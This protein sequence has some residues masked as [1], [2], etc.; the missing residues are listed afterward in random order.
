MSGGKPIRDIWRFLDKVVPAEW[1]KVTAA[2]EAALRRDAGISTPPE[3]WPQR[4]A[5]FRAKSIW[6]PA[7]GPPPGE[8]GCRVPADLLGAAE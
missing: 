2:D 8:P 5:G 3:P 1:A 7:W 4:V 6:L